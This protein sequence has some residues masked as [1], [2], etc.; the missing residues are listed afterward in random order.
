[1]SVR[2]ICVG[3]IDSI[4]VSVFEVILVEFDKYWIQNLRRAGLS[5]ARLEGP[6]ART[7]GTQTFSSLY[8]D[9][10]CAN[11]NFSQLHSKFDSLTYLTLL[12]V[13]NLTGCLAPCTYMEYR[14]LKKTTASSPSF[15]RKS[16]WKI[17]FQLTP[18]KETQLVMRNTSPYLLVETEEL[19]YTVESLGE[20]RDCLHSGQSW[21]GQNQDYPPQS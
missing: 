1:M 9:T 2:V 14:V 7:R 18:R 12:E 8:F 17:K 11:S 13:S 20:P 4:A 15:E 10:H 16:I 6:P 19:V 5:R 21:G 3:H